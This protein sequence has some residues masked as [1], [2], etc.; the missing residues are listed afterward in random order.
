MVATLRQYTRDI[1]KNLDMSV[2]LAMA[3]ERAWRRGRRGS[4]VRGQERAPAIV[5]DRD[6]L[7]TSM[8]QLRA[9][10]NVQRATT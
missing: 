9:P 6:S 2:E 5:Q 7:G 8:G 10:S 1:G 3:E 4:I